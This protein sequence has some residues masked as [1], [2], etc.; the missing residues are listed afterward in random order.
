MHLYIFH[1]PELISFFNF[2]HSDSVLYLLHLSTER[3]F[4]QVDLQTVMKATKDLVNTYV[5]SVLTK[6]NSSLQEAECSHIEII[7]H[8]QQLYR[9]SYRLYYAHNCTM[10]RSFPESR[11]ASTDGNCPFA[12]NYKRSTDLDEKVVDVFMY[13]DKR[14]LDRIEEG[15]MEELVFD[16]GDEDLPSDAD[17]SDISS[18][19]EDDES[20]DSALHDM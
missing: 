2:I 15:E 14:Y 10:N 1:S 8:M 12:E 16:A 13:K 7:Q 20:E 9:S 5:N 18:S 19:E 6:I 3:K 17:E 4:N 11:A